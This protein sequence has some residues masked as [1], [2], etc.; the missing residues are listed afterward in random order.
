MDQQAYFEREFQIGKLFESWFFDTTLPGLVIINRVDGEY[1]I[2]YSDLTQ[3]GGKGY[4]AL[5]LEKSGVAY[6]ELKRRKFRSRARA[7]TQ[8]KNWMELYKIK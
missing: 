8:V 1:R 4:K 2:Q 7:M 6:I 5:L 3:L